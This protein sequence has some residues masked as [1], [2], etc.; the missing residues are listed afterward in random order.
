MAAARPDTERELVARFGLREFVRRA[1]PQVDTSPLVWGWHIDA[2]CE[3]LEGVFW[4]QIRD[5]VINVPP[6]FSKSLL[7]SVLFP[8]WCWTLDP[9]HRWITV[10]YADDVA[11][12]DA[13]KHRALVASDWYQERWSEVRLPPTRDAG[14]AL[15]L[16]QNTQGGLRY[17]TTI[18]GALTGQHCDTAVIDDP[19]DPRGAEAV[20]GLGLDEVLRWWSQTLPTRFRDP[21]RSARVLVMQRL[22]ER[23]LA[24]EMQRQGAE[25][26]C[27][28]MRFEARHPHRYSKDPRTQEGELLDPVRYPAETV[29]TLETRMGP[30][31]VAAQFQQ[32]PA[33][34]GGAIFKEHWWRHWTELPDDGV[35]V[36]SWD[37]AFKSNASSDRVCGQVWLSNHPNNYLVDSYC[38]H[39][40]FTETLAAI[41]AMSAKYP[42]SKVLVEAKANGEAVV[43]VLKREITGLILVEPKGGKIARAHAVEGL[44]EAG[45]VLVPHETEARLPDGSRGCQWIRTY[46]AELEAFPRGVYDDQ[47]DATTQ[48][49]TK[50]NNSYAARLAAAVTA[51]ATSKR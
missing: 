4:R 22:H 24:G 15:S 19:I 3:H 32:R 5:L 35:W 30:T 17:T 10:S 9:E 23:D 49:L 28:P 1:W 42:R 47:V 27:L 37:L 25:V 41:R 44:F 21:P 33:P 7:A 46:K 29:K 12:R 31:V 34:K 48:A 51:G 38:A 36:Q 39:A 14:T 6:G 13:R 50:Q 40:S 11:L 2:I 16:W 43:D 20:S 8:A 18:R 45:N 26:L